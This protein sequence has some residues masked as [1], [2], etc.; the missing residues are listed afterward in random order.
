[1]STRSSSIRRCRPSASP[2]CAANC[3]T[4]ATPSPLLR[5]EWAKL[6]TPGRIQGLAERHLTLRP[7]EPTQFDTFDRLARASAATVPPPNADPIGAM[8]APT[9]P[10][11]TGSIPPPA[12]GAMTDARQRQNRRKAAGSARCVSRA[13]RPRRRSQRQGQGAARPRHRRFRRHLCV[14]ALRLVMFATVSDG[15]GGRRSV[16]QDAVATARPDILDRNGADPRHR[17]EDAVAVRRAAQDHRRR[18]GGRTAHRRA[19]RSRRQ[20]SARAAVVEARLRLAQARDHA[21]AAAGDLPARHSRH[22][23]PDREQARLSERADRSR[24]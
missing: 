1:M 10:D 15:H 7:I 16:A 11:T 5:A 14:I 18:R 8:L 6:D 12:S 23:L 19:A 24:T 22:R 3:A 20:R 4:S 9:A 2:S 17:R 21:Q 13:L